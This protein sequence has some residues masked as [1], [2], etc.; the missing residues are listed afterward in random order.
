MRALT[1]QAFTLSSNFRAD[2]SIELLE[3]VY[4]AIDDPTTVE[5]VAL[6]LE[7]ARALMLHKRY[8]RSIEISDRVVGRAE[9]VLPPAQVI[10]GLIT[11][12]TAIH[13]TRRIEG[14]SLLAGLVQ[15]ADE[16]DLPAQALRALNNHE[17]ALMMDAPGIPLERIDDFLERARRLGSAAW[18]NRA[19]LDSAFMYAIDHGDI[20]RGEALLDEAESYALN[21]LERSQARMTRAHLSVVQDPD[22]TDIGLMFEEAASW[23]DATDAQMQ[24]MHHSMLSWSMV[25]DGDFAGGLEHSLQV[26]ISGGL[27]GATF[28]ALGLGD[29]ESL[30]AAR[31]H[32][33]SIASG[34]RVGEAC[35][36]LLDAGASALAGSTDEA[37]ALFIE[38]IALLERIADPFTVTLARAMFSGR[39]ADAHPA[40]VEA[41]R[42]ARTWLRTAGFRRWE[43]LLEDFLPPME[44]AASESA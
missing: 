3:P 32:V 6:A 38:A 7:F 4:Q 34:R 24:G 8:D 27:F 16:H 35:T 36:L 22:A 9:E 21:D 44:S 11:R 20:A 17:Y 37:A 31:R 23:A 12:A 39:V 15:M 14:L 26:S 10:D 25:L 18:L 2:E 13:R 28:S 19:L 41:G 42:G 1:Q 30:D 29:A 5:E 43:V 40:A 33:D